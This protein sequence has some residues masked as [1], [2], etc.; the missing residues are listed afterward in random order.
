MT[1]L[2]AASA[3]G[4][5]IARDRVVEIVYAEIHRMAR[6]Q[7]RGERAEHT[8]GAT[9]LVH[10]TFLKLFK[11]PSQGDGMVWGDRR[12]FFSAAATAMRRV[13]VDHARARNAEKRGGPGR[14]ARIEADAVAAAT[15]MHP[16]DF[17]SLDEA[18]SRLEE[19]DARAAD[20]V[21]LRFYAGRENKEVAELLGVSDRTV[22]R[23]WEFARAWLFDAMGN[24]EVREDQA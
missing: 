3:G 23:D 16:S 19:V 10:E 8:L 14:L 21:R 24:S 1:Q 5:P 2:L 11:T 22:K 17:L 15:S 4:D 12:A 13:L 6:G 9:G 7:M 18:V 20:V